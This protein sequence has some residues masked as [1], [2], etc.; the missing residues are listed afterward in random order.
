MARRREDAMTTNRGFLVGQERTR[1][2]RSVVLAVVLML[3]STTI[4]AGQSA[5]A[6]T[7]WLA[8]PTHAAKIAAAERELVAVVPG[9]PEP[10]RLT[11]QRWMDL[12]K[13]P[14]LSVAVFDQQKLVWA[15]A[16]GVKEAEALSLR[17]TL[18]QYYDR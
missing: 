5:K 9:E 6:A 10:L 12:Y 15:K 18:K 2:V 14:G 16:Y 13:I 1:L 4:A 17:S 11:L 8:D 3:H 7:E